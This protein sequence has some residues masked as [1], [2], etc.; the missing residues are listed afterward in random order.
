MNTLKVKSRGIEFITRIGT[1]D[2][3]SFDEVVKRQ[4]YERK[5]FK[6][7]TGET[8]LDLG[9]NVG[10]F[11]CLA[12]SLG[13]IVKAYEPESN[14]AKLARHNLKI[15]GF[16]VIVEEK[17]IVHNS[18][19]DETTRFYLSN[20]K[21]GQW[22]HSIYKVKNNRYVDIPV[23]KISDILHG[24]DAVKMDIEGAEID[25][26]NSDINWQGVNK[27]CLEWHFDVNN[28]IPFFL[29]VMDKL[30]GRFDNVKHPKMPDALEYSWFPPA[31]IIFAWNS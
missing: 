27:L 23:V 29:S 13:A 17:A 25:I 19:Q 8:W 28:S 16:D 10:A 11:S 22:R 9:C 12:A 26:L 30:K 6:I 3:Q 15:N 20:T 14:N 24:V 2:R 7:E 18:W 21:H 5:Y 4:G 1:S 31:V